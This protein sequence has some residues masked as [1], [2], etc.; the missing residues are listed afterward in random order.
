[1][2]RALIGLGAN[3]GDRAQTLG[4]A[5]AR[6]GELA[7]PVVSRSRWYESPAVGGPA[8]QPAYLNGALVVETSLEPLVLLDA[9]QAIELELGR[10]R[11]L[12]WD[13]R[14]IDLDLLLYDD[15]RI[16]TPRLSVPHPRFAV[17]RFVL[18]PAREVAP[19][20][21]DPATGW[22]VER[23]FEHLLH[24]APYL[25]ITG[26]PGAGKT[27]VASRLAG[28]IG[29][30]L[31][32][33]P[34][35]GVANPASENDSAGPAHADKS[36]GHAWR[37][38]IEF[39]TRRAAVLQRA[40]WPPTGAADA[41]VWTTSDFWFGQSLAW[42]VA[43]G[44]TALRDSLELAWQRLASQ[45]VPPKLLA[46][47]SCPRNDPMSELIAEEVR[48]ARPAPVLWLEADDS[49]GSITAAVEQLL[50]AMTAMQ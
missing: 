38:E 28:Q 31:L 8:G 24:T 2:H 6:L 36:A 47:L 19:A 26:P 1:M 39:L 22:T 7:G 46:V 49:A 34:C 33:D 43:A 35:G 16:D 21:I 23:L 9:L 15:L 41:P 42:A 50:A 12:R 29:G 11:L 48:Q 17:R 14:T 40:D 30:R 45:T 27:S 13:A 32:V 4:H 20:M 10:A 37:R 5:V 25:A 44:G 18:E 3:L